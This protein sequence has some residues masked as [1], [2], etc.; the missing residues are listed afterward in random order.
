[1]A[2][3]K[4]VSFR[5]DLQSNVTDTLH[6]AGLQCAHAPGLVTNLVSLLAA[7]TEEGVPLS[8]AVFLCN[9]IF[10]LL[11]R[12]GVG[13]HVALG[14]GL[15]TSTAAKVILKAAGGLC[16]ENWKIYVQRSEDGATCGFG[17]FCG[18]NDPSSMSV[19]EVLLADAEPGFPIIRITQSATNKVEVRS[20]AGQSIEFRFNADVDV[21]NLDPASDVAG[22]AGAIAVSVGNQRQEFCAYVERLIT[23][24]L[25]RSHG[26]LLVVL[27]PGASELPTI[28][29]DGVRL[30]PALDLYQRFRLHLDEGKTAASVS[31]LQTANELVAGL[32]ASDGITVFTGSG[33]VIGYRAFI[34]SEASASH[35]DGG[36]RTRAFH[37]LANHLGP[38][39]TAVLFRS[40]DGRTE[41][42]VAEPPHD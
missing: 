22:L 8:P 18:A 12:A 27:P 31:K 1:M 14:E 13:E 40:Q 39:L 21:Y 15:Q 37:A 24:A 33:Q 36:A 26:A 19:D 35:S 2:I 3:G 25:K 23:S 28:L 11:Q 5:S 38:H 6:G 32:I 20:N 30:A 7:Y 10:E 16:G 4:S 34:H 41:L 17:V 9:S 29:E 42:R